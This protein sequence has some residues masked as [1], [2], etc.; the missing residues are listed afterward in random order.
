MRQMVKPDE[1][2]KTTPLIA[3]SACKGWFKNTRQPTQQRKSTCFGQVVKKGKGLG[4]SV[5][6]R[7]RLFGFY[8]K[9]KA[10][11]LKLGCCIRKHN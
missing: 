9:P 10:L 2:G 4:E 8:C 7:V 11:G 3:A 6:P 5:L 1:T